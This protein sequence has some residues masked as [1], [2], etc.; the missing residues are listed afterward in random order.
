MSS[1]LPS[2]PA[3]T[4]QAPTTMPS[5]ISP[6]G[7]VL[8]GGAGIAGGFAA[9]TVTGASDPEMVKLIA[10]YGMGT[11]CLAV[12]I[13]LHIYNVKV[14]I[15]SMIS[16]SRDD[17]SNVISAFRLELAAERAQC[18][19]D[20]LRLEELITENLKGINANGA[21]AIRILDRIDDH[22]LQNRP[23]PQPTKPKGST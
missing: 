15:P 14:T 16:A 1:G 21:T 19:S 17:L 7:K 5:S 12:L 9:G 22:A 20:H 8:A 6:W 10:N 18:H 4:T 13:G 23:Q 11:V 3:P 2:P